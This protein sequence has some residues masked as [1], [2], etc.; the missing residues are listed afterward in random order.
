MQRCSRFPLRTFLVFKTQLRSKGIKGSWPMI[1]DMSTQCHSRPPHPFFFHC[2]TLLLSLTPLYTFPLIFCSFSCTL[3]QAAT[4]GL[5]ISTPVPTTLVA[6]RVSSIFVFVFAICACL[7]GGD[8]SQRNFAKDR[9]SSTIHTKP[10]I[11]CD[12]LPL[13]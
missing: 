12:N 9:Q 11:F 6:S 3:P 4:W 13:K 7:R 8:C 1:N 10:I 5:E 2:K